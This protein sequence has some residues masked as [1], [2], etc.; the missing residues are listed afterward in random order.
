M[1]K[2]KGTHLHNSFPRANI[3]LILIVANQL[4]YF[5]NLP[6]GSASVNCANPMSRTVHHSGNAG[7]Y[8]RARGRN[9]RRKV[10]RRDFKLQQANKTSISRTNFKGF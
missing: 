1:N 10:L 4:N 7:G 8:V 5:G 3:F 6:C 9:L 2:G